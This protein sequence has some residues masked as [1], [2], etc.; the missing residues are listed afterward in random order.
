MATVPE[1]TSGTEGGRTMGS[2]SGSFS[3]GMSLR[4]TL[5]DMRYSS[6]NCRS[7]IST[8]WPDSTEITFRSVLAAD[9]VKLQHRDLVR[10]GSGPRMRESSPA[11]VHPEASVRQTAATDGFQEKGAEAEEG[12]GAPGS[13]L[14]WDLRQPHAPSPSWRCSLDRVCRPAVTCAAISIC[15]PTCVAV[16]TSQL[17]VPA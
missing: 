11:P 16:G 9:H 13:G 14:V 17:P 5:C 8:T 4:Q 2:G 3:M 15:L 10:C 12:A 7:N 1:G 6:W